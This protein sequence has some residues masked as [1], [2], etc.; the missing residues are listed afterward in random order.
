MSKTAVVL[1]AGVS[2]LTTAVTLLRNGFKNVVVIGEHVPGDNSSQYTSPWAGASILSVAKH[3]DY[4]LQEIDSYT[5]KEFNRLADQEPEA[6]VMYCQGVKY[7]Q[8]P[9]LPGE[10]V[11]WVRKIYKNVEKIPENEL[12]PGAEYG[13]TFETFTAN[14]PKYLKWLVKTL[15]NLGGH[16]ERRSF[17][18]IQ[19]VID[20]YEDAEIV[21]NCTGLGS[22]F[23]E[24]V[25]DH[26]MY[27]V[28]GQ[29][30]L[31]RAPHIK[32]QRYIDGIGLWTYI[33]P[34][35]DGTVICGGTV[36]TDND[37]TSPDEAITKSILERAYRLNPD[38]THGKGFELKHFDIISVNVGFR[39]ARRG[40]IRLEK[41][42]R[43]R[44]NGDQVVLCHNYGHGSGGYQSSWGSA[45]K[46]LD[47]LNNDRISKL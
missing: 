10:D 45:K 27:P 18:S 37:Q 6:H 22:R 25:K 47:L 16:L 20:E 9:A 34:R 13:Y 36:D 3:D 38:L 19:Q 7:S 12:I 30:V 28:R 8:E 24:D 26:N 1:G 2:G 46:V 14:V 35:D 29:T 41:E 5:M 32:T 21:V 11:Y 4:R 31:I 33:I 15:K 44:P 40:G 17:K 23:L 39:P 43:R 42:T